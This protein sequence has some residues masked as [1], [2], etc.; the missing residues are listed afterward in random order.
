MGPAQWSYGIFNFRYGDNDVGI[1]LDIVRSCSL[2][3]IAQW[4]HTHTHT[5]AHTSRAPRFPPAPMNFFL[6]LQ[7]PK[8]ENWKENGVLILRFVF[9]SSS[10]HSPVFPP[11]RLQRMCHVVNAILCLTELQACGVTE[12]R[13]LFELSGENYSCFTFVLSCDRISN[14]NLR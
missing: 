14:K 3:C 11:L 1:K 10:L 12:R 6:P 7:K 2:I 9:F 13:L 8:L 4:T 5:H